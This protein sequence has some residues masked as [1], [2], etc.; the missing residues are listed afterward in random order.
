MPLVRID[1][2]Q[3]KTPEYHRKIGDMVYRAHVSIGSVS[4][5]ADTRQSGR[6]LRL[7]STIIGSHRAAIA[8]ANTNSERSNIDSTF[9]GQRCL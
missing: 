3:G 9:L 4:H 6:Y 5:P 7:M 2:R 1:L 8:T